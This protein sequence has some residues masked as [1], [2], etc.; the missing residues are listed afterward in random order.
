[1]QQTLLI[2]WT[3]HILNIHLLPFFFAI[4]QIQNKLICGVYAFMFTSGRSKIPSGKTQYSQ[5]LDSK[6][7][8]LAY[9][10]CQ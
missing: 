8:N 6:Y 1:M 2:V 4:I 7:A 10:G 9:G 3:H 5:I